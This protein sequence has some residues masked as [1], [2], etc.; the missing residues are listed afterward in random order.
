[1]L[2]IKK[3]LFACYLRSRSELNLIPIIFLFNFYIL[4]ILYLH[5]CQYKF[6]DNFNY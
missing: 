6:I 1:M 5:L 3:V 2:K 4:N